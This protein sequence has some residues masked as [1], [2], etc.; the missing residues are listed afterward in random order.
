MR[1]DN[2][3]PI[4]RVTIGEDGMPARTAL[5]TPGLPPGDHDLY[6]EPSEELAALR[7]AYEF[8]LPY[9]HVD[10][11]VQALAIYEPQPTPLENYIG[12]LGAKP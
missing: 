12:S 6:C 11:R 7:A 1:P 3:W 4:A 2:Q 10:I 5:Y 8:V 9:L